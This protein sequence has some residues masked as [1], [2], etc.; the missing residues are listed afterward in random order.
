MK[1]Q[2]KSPRVVRKGKRPGRP[3]SRLPQQVL[4]E[5]GPPPDS[6]LQLAR[7]ATRLLT[8]ATWLQLKGEIGTELAGNIRAFVGSITRAQ[9]ADIAAELE[10]MLNAEAKDQET[11]D[12]GP[13][14]EKKGAVGVGV[15]L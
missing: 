15:A 3:K 13:R 8:K 6:P 5:L 11:D 2:R 10:R 1:K 14:L 4:D 7:W 9:Q 12:I